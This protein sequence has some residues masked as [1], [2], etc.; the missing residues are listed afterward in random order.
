MNLEQWPTKKDIPPEPEGTNKQEEKDKIK[1]PLSKNDAKDEANM[2]ES[3]LGVMPDFYGY[4]RESK[5]GKPTAE[6]YDKALEVVEEI[7]KM[8]EEEPLTKKILTEIARLAVKSSLGVAEVFAAMA[9]I[10]GV[11]GP[12]EIIYQKKIKVLESL[13]DASTKLKGLK[14]E[15][16]EF[17]KRDNLVQKSKE[18]KESK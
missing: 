4:M 3:K 7:K 18:L 10:S 16:E 17:S 13:E 5:R 8:A 11:S 2:M 1:E 15:A 12:A 6:D 9:G 14:A